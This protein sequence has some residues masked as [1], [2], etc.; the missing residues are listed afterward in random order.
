MNS[1]LITNINYFSIIRE[2]LSFNPYWNETKEIPGDNARIK[3]SLVS[4]ANDFR[5]I[6]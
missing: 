6:V 4:T 3:K 1:G 2:K 5:T